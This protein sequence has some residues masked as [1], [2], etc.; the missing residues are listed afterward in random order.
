VDLRRVTVVLAA[1]LVTGEARAASGAFAVDDAAVDAP[2]RCKVETWLSAANN[3]MSDW[4][5]AI[6][7]T[8]AL[9]LL[10]HRFELGA[11]FLRTSAAGEHGSGLS[12]KAKTP[13][14]GLDFASNDRFGVALVWGGSFDAATAAT[15]TMFFNAPVTLRITNALTL[16]INTGYHE[17]KIERY[18]AVTWGAGF[19]FNLKSLALDK[20]TLIAETFS[21]H[22]DHT[23]TQ[24]GLRFAPLA[25]L[26]IDLIYGYNLASEKASWLTLG[27]NYRF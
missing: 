19:E 25:K 23:A 20:F 9:P 24:I 6:A 18:N 3:P 10:G 17:D 14:P 1:L 5:A 22:R 27:L 13:F 26:D 11:T 2:G 4:N 16:N 12:V 21:N 7:P 8:C 15:H